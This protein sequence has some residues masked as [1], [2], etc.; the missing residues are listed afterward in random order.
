M[1][2][3]VFIKA[4]IPAWKLRNMFEKETTVQEFITQ[5]PSEKGNKLCMKITSEFLV[6]GKAFNDF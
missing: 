5:L 4:F 1:R 3:N 6:S 2:Q